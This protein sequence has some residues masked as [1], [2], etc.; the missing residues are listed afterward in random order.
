MF[1]DYIR[2]AKYLVQ[3]AQDAERTLS[4]SLGIG[5]PISSSAAARSSR[6]RVSGLA[7]GPQSDFPSRSPDSGRI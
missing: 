6:S 5:S 7:S 4:Q 3:L 1:Q 2:M